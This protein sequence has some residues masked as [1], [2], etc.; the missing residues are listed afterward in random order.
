M[1]AAQ[2]GICIEPGNPSQ[3]VEAVLRLAQDSNLR[4]T[5]GRNGRRYWC[6]IFRAAVPPLFILKCWM[7]CWE[8]RMLVQWR[9]KKGVW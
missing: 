3:L 8:K 5:L 2:A 7:G 4:E 1:E 6:S 9:R